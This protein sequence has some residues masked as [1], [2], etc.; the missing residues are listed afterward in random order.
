MRLIQTVSA[1]A[2]SAALVLA[3]TAC[4]GSTTTII[5]PS[6][7]GSS[8]SA[9]TTGAPASAS[10]APASPKPAGPVVTIT[11]GTGA[12]GA[13]PSTGITVTAA[14][15]TLRTVTVRTPGDPVSGSYSAGRTSWH[16]TWALN[17]S[18]SYEAT[19]T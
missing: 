17:V 9:T 5:E 14:G 11:P 4:T 12:T 13:D 16:S 10:S 3:V 2:A 15:G 1:V 6:G 18:L 19:A 7:G 8:P